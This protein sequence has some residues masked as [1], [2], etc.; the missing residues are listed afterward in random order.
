M[1]KKARFQVTVVR[2][3]AFTA[4]AT[5]R[6]LTIKDGATNLSYVTLSNPGF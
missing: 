4:V 1:R 5:I 6:G 2:Q 3:A